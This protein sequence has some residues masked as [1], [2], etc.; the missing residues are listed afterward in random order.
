MAR[1]FVNLTA[2]AGAFLVAGV[3]SLWG[4]PP[5]CTCGEIK[6]W[7]GSVFDS[8]N[9]QHIADWYTLGHILHGV[10]IA[11][12]GRLLFPR[13]SY[14]T[15]LGVAIVTGVGWEII[16]HTNWVLG[17]FRATTINAGYH[18]DSVLNAV[19]DY[20]W[21]L[22]GFFTAYHLRKTLVVGMIA[23]LELSAAFIA[24]D[25]LALSTLML[26]YPLES[27]ENWQ[28]ELNPAREQL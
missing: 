21:M 27:V 23:A 15:L 20:I 26:V 19:S 7:V 2:V 28:Q 11:F 5:I 18:G 10:L 4:Q 17:K 22:M 9:S 6:L 3:L 13:L 8:G 1:N 12:L 24:R 25:S 16:E 14:E